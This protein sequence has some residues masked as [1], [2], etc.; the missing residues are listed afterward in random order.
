[1]EKIKELYRKDPLPC[2]KCLVSPV[3]NTACEDFIDVCFR[4]GIVPQPLPGKVM[5]T[6]EQKRENK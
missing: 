4:N 3:C 1:M 5:I 2:E 6:A